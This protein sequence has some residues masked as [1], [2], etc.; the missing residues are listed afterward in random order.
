MAC[1][2]GDSAARSPHQQQPEMA[3]SHRQQKTR[4][5]LSVSKILIEMKYV[6]P[7]SL[8]A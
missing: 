1:S 8:P 4:S 6:Q 5:N 3:F 7:S 2:F